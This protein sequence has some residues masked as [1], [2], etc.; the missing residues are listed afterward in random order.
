VPHITN[1]SLQPIVFRLIELC[2]D[3]PADLVKLLEAD[4]EVSKGVISAMPV[5]TCRRVLGAHEGIFA[6]KCFSLIDET[7]QSYHAAEGLLEGTEGT[8]RDGQPRQRL[9]PKTR[10][11]RC[12]PLQ[13]LVALVPNTLM[14]GKL[15]NMLHTFFNGLAGDYRVAGV[16]CD[17]TMALH[18]AERPSGEK[19]ARA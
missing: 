15:V 9:P 7:T 6:K 11:Q 4:D 14:Y 8:D 12:A 3:L 2:K 13:E 19:P 17:L 16:R 1:A 18:E 10:R 5:E